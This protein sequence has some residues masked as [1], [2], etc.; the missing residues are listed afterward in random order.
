MCLIP[1]ALWTIG[2][3]NMDSGRNQKT[4][5]KSQLF[6]S[7]AKL[8]QLLEKEKNKGSEVKLDF[9]ADNPLLLSFSAYIDSKLEVEDK[10]SQ[11]NALQQVG[12]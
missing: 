2:Y 4:L 5:L 7:V 8:L 6:R 10:L 9:A 11:I 1:T 12:D 3:E